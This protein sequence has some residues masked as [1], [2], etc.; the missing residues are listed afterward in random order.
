MAQV[1]DY[2]QLILQ[3]I[4]G[5]PQHYL[6]EVADFVY[7]LREKKAK[8]EQP[9]KPLSNRQQA[10]LRLLQD[11]KH[12]APEIDASIDIQALIDETHVREL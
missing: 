6:G 4:K 2:E 8:Q 12:N 1:I 5:L 9:S 7:F 10:M 3:G 11:A